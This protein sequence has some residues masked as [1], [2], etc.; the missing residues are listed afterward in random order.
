M[1]QMLHSPSSRRLSSLG[2]FTPFV[3]LPQAGQHNV[4]ISGAF[5]LSQA[6][7]HFRVLAAG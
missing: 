3:Y 6:H 1:L 4:G 5:D 2:L 7:V